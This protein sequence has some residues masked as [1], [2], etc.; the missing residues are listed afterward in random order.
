MTKN[1]LVAIGL[2]AVLAGPAAAQQDHGHGH[3]QDAGAVTTLPE[4]SAAAVQAYIA[5]MERMHAAM[6]TLAYTGDADV[7]FA[8]GMIPHHEAAIDMARTVLEHGSDPKIRDLAAA[9]IEAQEGE[10]AVLEAWLAEHGRD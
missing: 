3:G 10:I 6:S 4:G 1:T 2:A 7:D 5:S 9:I 8:R